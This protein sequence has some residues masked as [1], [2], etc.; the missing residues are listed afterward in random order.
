M[1]SSKA[2]IVETPWFEVKSVAIRHAVVEVEDPHGLGDDGLGGLVAGAEHA[3]QR[4]LEVGPI[5]LVE[6][7]GVVVSGV[8]GGHGLFFDLAGGHLRVPRSSFHSRHTGN[9]P[10]SV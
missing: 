4:G 8:R 6:P 9:I 1:D 3:L 10:S 5:R 2:C 7:A